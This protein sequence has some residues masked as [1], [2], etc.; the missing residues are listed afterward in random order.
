MSGF[1]LL[2]SLVLLLAGRTEEQQNRLNRLG[3]T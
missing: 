2:A 3:V 1:L